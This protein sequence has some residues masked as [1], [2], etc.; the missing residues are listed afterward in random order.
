[1]V[2]AAAGRVAAAV[3]A[4]AARLAQ[5]PLRR[6]RAAVRPA[7][8]LAAQPDR[9]QPARLQR[10]AHA[11]GRRRLG[12]AGLL[13]LDLV[14]R[15]TIVT[16]RAGRDPG[17]A[18]DPPATATHDVAAAPAGRAANRHP[19]RHADGPAQARPVRRRTQLP[20]P[21]PGADLPGAG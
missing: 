17:A 18:D 2:R 13:R 5:Q 6:R 14:T 16:G 3:L 9:P 12:G 20:G 19:A 8:P 21:R 11:P 1:P 4:V 15:P 10:P 7:R